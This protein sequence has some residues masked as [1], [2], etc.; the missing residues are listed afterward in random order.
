MIRAPNRTQVVSVAAV[1][2]KIRN[3]L[4]Q[5]DR[6]TQRVRE[7]QSLHAF[8]IAARRAPAYSHRRRERLAKRTAE[9]DA[10]VSVPRLERLRAALAKMQIAIDVVF[11]RGNIELRQN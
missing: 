4:L 7:L 2:Q 11:D 8:E 1:A 5:H 9:N 3:R 10:P 6:R